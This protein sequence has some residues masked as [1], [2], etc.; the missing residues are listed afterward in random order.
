MTSIALPDPTITLAPVVNLNDCDLSRQILP[1]TATESW[2]GYTISIIESGISEI[3]KVIYSVAQKTFWSA[4]VLAADSFMIATIGRKLSNQVLNL[5]EYIKGAPGSLLKF[6]QII[7]HSVAAIDFVQIASDVHYFVFSKGAS[8]A[9]GLTL[10][11][12]IALF[13]ANIGGALLWLQDMGFIVLKNTAAKL[14]EVRLFSFVP[15]AIS[16]IPVVREFKALQTVAKA[17]G[18]LHVF[19]FVKKLSLLPLVLRGLDIG[20]ACFAVD[21]AMKLWKADSQVKAV[22]MALDLSTYLSELFLSA[23][24]YVGV[25]NVVALGVAGTAC[26]AF[27]T[28]SYLYKAGYEKELKHVPEVPTKA[29]AD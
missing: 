1:T 22:S 24:I 2:L 9:D 6:A 17:I 18:E 29:V 14:G 4:S 3:G 15:K 23:I 21:A 13:A 8:H 28:F 20:F 11:G 7:K 5:C 16:S 10:T 26:I 19:N 25:T 12:R 27:A